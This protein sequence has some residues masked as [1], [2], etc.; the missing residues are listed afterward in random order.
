MFFTKLGT[1]VAWMAFVL[2][3]FR[4]ATGFVVASNLDTAGF[5]AARYIGSSTSGR[6]IDQ[7]L[8]MIAFAIGLGILAEISRRV[9]Q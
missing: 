9:G 5:D 4:V 6:A 7:G 2:G 8:M 1:I 3:V